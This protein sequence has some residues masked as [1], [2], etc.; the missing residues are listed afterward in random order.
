M[1]NE[2]KPTTPD[3]LDNTCLTLTQS[4]V[5]SLYTSEYIKAMA[6]IEERKIEKSRDF[7]N[8]IEKLETGVYQE[9]PISKR[10]SNHIKSQ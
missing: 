2:I 3:R 5:Q 8:Y 9:R 4:P 10:E 6:K 1:P 7:S